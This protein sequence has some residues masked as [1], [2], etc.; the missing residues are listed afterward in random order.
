MLTFF[1][2]ICK[3][4]WMHVISMLFV[5]NKYV[6]LKMRA[7]FSY[8]KCLFD[9]WNDYSL[10]FDVN[11]W[12]FIVLECILPVVW[13]VLI[14][15]KWIA[16]TDALSYA[17]DRMLSS[18]FFSKFFDFLKTFVRGWSTAL[19]LISP[20]AGNSDKTSPLSLNT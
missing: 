16:A 2:R 12:V 17:T 11:L 6:I 9:P 8:L 7:S 3:R 1:I 18:P 20:D 15:T 14:W 10:P 4:L 5:C 13:S 19:S